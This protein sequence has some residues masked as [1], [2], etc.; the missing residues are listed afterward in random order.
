VIQFTDLEMYF[1][2]QNIATCK[3]LQHGNTTTL[4]YKII[5]RSL[6]Y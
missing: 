3:F 1:V 4:Q 6:L 2:L 5:L